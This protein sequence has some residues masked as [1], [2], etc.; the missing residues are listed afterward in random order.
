LPGQLLGLT[1]YLVREEGKYK[2]LGS[3]PDGLEPIGELVREL[4]GKNDIKGAQWWLDEVAGDLEPRADGT[5]SPAMSG[6][7]SGRTAASRGPNAIR[8]AAAMLIAEGTGDAKAIQTL[9]EERVKAALALDK[10]LVDKALCEALLK[11]RKWDDLIVVARRLQG[12]NTFSEEGFRYF[13]KAA[14]GARKWKDLE[15]ESQ[16]R[17][18]G[19]ALN[20]AA[21]RSLVLAKAHLGD[22]AG[23]LELSAKLSDKLYADAEDC[24]LAAWNAVLAGK[25]D[26]AVLTQLKKV[27][28]QTG[29][30][31]NYQ[32]TLAMVEA[33]L[34]SPDDAQQTLLKGMAHE[35]YFHL[36][37]LAWIAYARI[38]D[39]YG[40]PIEAEAAVARAKSGTPD[41]DMAEWARLLAQKGAAPVQRPQ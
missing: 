9:R 20:L 21:V 19:N 13:V 27:K 28:D 18:E 1:F 40:F 35:D 37:P 17:M 36:S 3:S 5:G 22:T 23:A 38:C 4:L 10:S 24:A 32:Y 33:I 2:L 12:S 39:Q 16:K 14:T 6:L 11:A 7:W 15:T 25:V 26:E 31:T 29:S 30:H 34:G 8:T 41:D